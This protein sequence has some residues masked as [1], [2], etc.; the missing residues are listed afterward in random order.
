MSSLLINLLVL[1]FASIV[2]VR[3]TTLIVSSISAIS[4]YFKISEFTVAFILM[5][6]V[7]SLPEIAI[8]V[9]SALNGQ[10]RL[11]LGTALGSNLADLTIVIAI[12]TL[13]AGGIKV[14]SIIARKDSLFM[15]L[16]ALIPLIMMTDGKISR[17]DGIIL[18]IF[19]F[20]Y[21]YRLLSQRM[22]FTTPTG[23]FRNHVIFEAAK[24]VTAVLFL[25]G[26]SQV[27]VNSATNIASV[28]EI[29]LVIVGLILIAAGTSLPELAYELKAVSTKHNEQALGDV[30]GSVVANSTLV[31]A[32]AA[33][34]SPIVIQDFAAIIVTIGFLIL[35][36]FF[37]VIGIYTDKEL[38]VREALIL[39]LIYFIFIFSEFGLE[40]FHKSI[41]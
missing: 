37:F 15:A 13:V 24:F 2:L 3:A 19:Y 27:L 8:A 4:A 29:P 1:I 5:A 21:M 41:L 10:S 26:A 25:F 12:P 16:F 36:L 38:E 23:P 34:I 30:F 35:V 14:R 9:S 31:L 7:T 20:L 28:L 22:H 6:F 39:L 11:A 18:V 17:P 40:I 33:L 32:V